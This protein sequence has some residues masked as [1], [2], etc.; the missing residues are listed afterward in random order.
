MHFN[1]KSQLKATEDFNRKCIEN[2]SSLRHIPNTYT[3]FNDWTKCKCI[4]CGKEKNVYY[5]QAYN[6]RV[7]CKCS[8]KPRAKTIDILTPLDIW[9]KKGYGNKLIQSV[10]NLIPI[11]KTFS[12]YRSDNMDFYCNAGNHISNKSLCNTLKGA[13]C[14]ECFGKGFNTKANAVIYVLKIYVDGIHIGYKIGITNKTSRQRVKHI[15]KSTE[16]TFDIIYEYESDG[17]TIQSIERDILNTL[18]VRGYISKDMMDDGST[19]TFN[20]IYLPLVVSMIFNLT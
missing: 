4:K 16:L 19:E 12:G 10:P 13:D 15:T 7:S 8:R 5:S 17:L 11:V 20:P 18:P 1:D 6:S 2:G 3:H 9:N 14:N